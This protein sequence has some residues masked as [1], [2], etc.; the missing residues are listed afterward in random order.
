MEQKAQGA[1]EYLLIIGAAILVVAI[2]IIALSG[3]LTGA[4]EEQGDMNDLN[5]AKE[6]LKTEGGL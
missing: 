3:V 4:T 1:I 5:D 6:K 2:V